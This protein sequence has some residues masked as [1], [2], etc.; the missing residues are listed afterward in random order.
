[1]TF[2]LFINI[3]YNSSA[4]IKIKYF[5]FVG[6][7]QMNTYIFVVIPSNCYDFRRF[8]T[9]LEAPTYTEY[10]CYINMECYGAQGGGWQKRK[11][12][13]GRSVQVNPKIIVA[14]GARHFSI[15]ALI[16]SCDSTEHFSDLFFSFRL[17]QRLRFF[18]FFFIFYAIILLLHL[19]TVFH[20]HSS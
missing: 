13:P 6:Y 12:K 2:I 19:E 15:Y 10:I 14:S 4:W 8:M 11:V 20:F 9:N 18:F 17:L 5:Y 3:F 16:N 7:I 1:M